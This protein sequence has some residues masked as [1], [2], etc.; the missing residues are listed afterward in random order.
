MI[1]SS[2]RNLGE[3][4]SVISRNVLIR[5]IFVMN[6][7]SEKFEAHFPLY[8]TW[9]LTKKFPIEMFLEMMDSSVKNLGEV[10]YDNQNCLKLKKTQFA[11][12]F[13]MS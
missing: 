1:D 11:D 4:E 6:Q 13:E 7:I 5:N 3:V 10:E 2:V 9:F 12:K 8:I